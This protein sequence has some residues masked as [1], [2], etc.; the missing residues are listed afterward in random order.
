LPETRSLGAPNHWLR[1]LKH[2]RLARDF[3]T[4][5]NHADPNS[6]FCR[7]IQQKRFKKKMQTIK[8]ENHRLLA[9]AA[10]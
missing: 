3:D 4:P 5:P 8:K 9:I 7:V 1:S 2:V 6:A 10:I